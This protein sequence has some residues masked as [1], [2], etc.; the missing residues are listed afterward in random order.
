GDGRRWGLSIA[1]SREDPPLE[2]AGG[3][4]TARVLLGE[5]PF[6][7][8]N[9]DVHCDHPLAALAGCDLGP[10]LGHI[11]L[12][13]NP[14][15]RPQGD[16]SLNAGAAEGRLGGEVHAGLWSD[17][18]TPERLAELNRAFTRTESP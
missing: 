1:W 4:A 12:V 17:V 9:A 2:T 18:G 6:V 14:E 13:P 16:F 5:A 10:R 7:L 15:F 11:V 3:I 8:V